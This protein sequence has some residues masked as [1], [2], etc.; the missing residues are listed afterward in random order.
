M[1]VT[2][3]EGSGFLPQPMSPGSTASSNLDKDTFL[4]L[5]VTQLKYQDPL[6]PTD[7][8]QFLAQSAQFSTLEKMEVV[9]QQSA[10]A[11]AAQMAFG[12][13]N[14][15]GRPVTYLDEGG[16]EVT[17]SVESVRFGATGPM[18]SVDG[19][20][21]AMNNLVSIGQASATSTPTAE[22]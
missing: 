2:A 7:Q 22:S 3:T 18:L 11:F 1:T 12:A 6:N 20:E 5:L 9:A 4:Q 16:Q 21:I 17:G 14:L 19:V 10:Q 15:V 13:S 8:T